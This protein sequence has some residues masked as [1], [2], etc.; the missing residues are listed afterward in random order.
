MTKIGLNLPNDHLYLIGDFLPLVLVCVL[1]D[2]GGPSHFKCYRSSLEIS[3][4]KFNLLSHVT[5][6][7]LAKSKT[8]LFLSERCNTFQII[9]SSFA[10]HYVKI[11]H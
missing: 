4:T 2:E 9:I 3:L 7:C 5:S 1:V 6:R 11:Q 10:H 8:K